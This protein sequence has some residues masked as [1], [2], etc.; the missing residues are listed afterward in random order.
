MGAAG[1]FFAAGLVAGSPPAGL[2]PAGLLAAGLL[3]VAGFPVAGV[4]LGA[5]E[6]GEE[7]ER[8][9][10]A[11]EPAAAALCPGPADEPPL[12]AEHPPATSATAVIKTAGSRRIRTSAP[13]AFFR[14]FRHERA[15]IMPPKPR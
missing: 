10:G 9:A 11:R 5:D 12:V 8:E 13:R 14:L 15:S 2:P 4:V 6:A 1:F 7:G 3:P